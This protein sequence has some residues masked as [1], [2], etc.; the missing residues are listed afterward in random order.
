MG[1]F[2]YVFVLMCEEYLVLYVSNKETP[3]FVCQQFITVSGLGEN[4][5]Q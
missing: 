1:V 2:V 4:R 3:N 5:K